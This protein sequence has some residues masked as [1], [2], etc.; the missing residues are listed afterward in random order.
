MAA[1]LE[2]PGTGA[3]IVE[4]TGGL[5]EMARCL[6]RRRLVSPWITIRRRSGHDVRRDFL[7]AACQ[8]VAEGKEAVLFLRRQKDCPSE[9][10]G[11]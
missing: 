11:I 10:S 4:R 1:F 7:Q 5:A 8:N 9:Y 2:I 3:Q 6:D